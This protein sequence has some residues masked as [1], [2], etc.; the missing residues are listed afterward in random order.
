MAKWKWKLMKLPHDLLYTRL[1]NS[2]S[3]WSRMMMMKQ[4]EKASFLPQQQNINTISFEFW[5][6]LFFPKYVSII[7]S[8]EIT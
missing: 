6:L 7:L 2:I 8:L 3:C 5:F 4:K 1:N